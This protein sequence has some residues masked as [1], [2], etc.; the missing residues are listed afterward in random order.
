LFGSRTRNPLRSAA[1]RVRG[2]FVW[3]R[4]AAQHGMPKQAGGPGSKKYSC[5][6]PRDAAPARAQVEAYAVSGDAVRFLAAS[7]LLQLARPRVPAV[8]RRLLAAGGVGVLMQMQ[9]IG[10]AS[11]FKVGAQPRIVARHDRN[12][13]PGHGCQEGI[14][15]RSDWFQ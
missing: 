1:L 9:C 12:K 14:D 15:W 5:R 4:D 6:L 2:S 11:T 3:W 10:H 7:A 13:G 8:Q